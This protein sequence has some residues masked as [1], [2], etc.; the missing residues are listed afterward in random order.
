LT[1]LFQRRGPPRSN[2]SSDGLTPLTG[3]DR[4]RPERCHQKLVP[5]IPQCFPP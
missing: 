5:K 2:R 1:T 4:R 3:R